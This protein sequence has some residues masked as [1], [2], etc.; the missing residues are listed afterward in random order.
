MFQRAN[1]LDIAYLATGH[2]AQ[3]EY[4]A[5]TGRYWLKKAADLSKDQSYVLYMLNQEQLARIQ[6]PLGG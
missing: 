5:D 6:L 3:I 4:H 2:Y 1:E